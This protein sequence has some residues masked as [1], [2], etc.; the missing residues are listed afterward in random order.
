MEPEK[1]EL[2]SDTIKSLS[3][4][5][6]YLTLDAKILNFIMTEFGQELIKNQ[7]F[8]TPTEV[9]KMFRITKEQQKTFRHRL[10]DPLP[11]H[12]EEKE[13]G[14]RNCKILYKTE[15]FLKW[16]ERNFPEVLI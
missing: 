16:L 4:E 15:T 7:F 11:Y 3:R 1:L 5:C 13:G 9:E 10:S 12:K 6:Y 2:N 14:C 8:I